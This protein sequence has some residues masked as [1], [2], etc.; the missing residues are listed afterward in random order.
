MVT[1]SGA[2]G[3]LDARRRGILR[4]PWPRYVALWHEAAHC[5]RAI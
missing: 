2:R 3:W 1:P 5:R 4:S